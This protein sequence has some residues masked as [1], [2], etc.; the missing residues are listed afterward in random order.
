MKRTRAEDDPPSHLEEEEYDP[1]VVDTSE[2]SPVARAAEYAALHVTVCSL[3]PDELIV[4][5]NVLAKVERNKRRKEN[6]TL[7]IAKDVPRGV[8]STMRSFLAHRQ[9]AL[10]VSENP[11]DQVKCAVFHSG[12]IDGKFAFDTGPFSETLP[13]KTL[14]AV[15]SRVGWNTN[16]ECNQVWAGDRPVC[17]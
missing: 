8:T 4:L 1:V 6:C 9:L 17:L 2:D 14:Q 15:C 7:L 5:G 10:L 16:S 11:E 13:N 12:T 3:T